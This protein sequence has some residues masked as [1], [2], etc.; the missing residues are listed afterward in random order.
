MEESGDLIEEARL[1][2]LR[3]V[4]EEVTEETDWLAL[5]QTIRSRVNKFLF[6]KT[7]RR[8]MVM[9]VIQEV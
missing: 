7:G 5:R 4:S 3:T 8:P 9:P 2:I 1:L 6:E